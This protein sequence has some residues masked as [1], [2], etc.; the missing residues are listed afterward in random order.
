MSFKV[1]GFDKLEKQLK[2][3]EKAA[4]D[5]EKEKYIPFENLFTKSFML[6]YT[7]FTTFD[8]LLEDGNFVVNSEEDFKAIPDDEFDKHIAATTRFSKWEDMLNHA[9]EIYVSKKL[10]L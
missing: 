7:N 10:G 1:K 4:K 8:E 6:K 9:T 3:M 5:L 2:Q